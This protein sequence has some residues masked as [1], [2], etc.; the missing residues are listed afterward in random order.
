MNGNNKQFDQFK[1]YI[2][3]FDCII[4]SKDSYRFKELLK[5]IKDNES[6][7]LESY[8]KRKKEGVYY[9]NEK[10]SRFI[11]KKTIVELINKN[12]NL[13]KNLEIHIKSFKDLL[14]VNQNLK[15]KI[16]KILL[17]LSICDPTCGSGVFLTCATNL[18]FEVLQ[19]LGITKDPIEIK[20]Q[21]LRNIYGLDINP[22]AIKLCSIKL[23]AWLYKGTTFNNI[24]NL[25]SIF[26]NLKIKNTLFSTDW[27]RKLFYKK[28]FDIIVGNPPY[29]NILS[30]EEKNSLKNRNLF[31][32][33]IYCAF[34][35]RAL[36]WIDTGII[37]FLIPKSFLLRQG[38]I[39]FR[40]NFLSNASI[41]KIYDIGANLFESATNEVQ[42]IIYQKN[43]NK[44]VNLD[45]YDYPKNQICTYKN[46]EFDDLRICVNLN[47]PLSV[48]SKK[49][50]AYTYNKNC[51]FCNS[52]AIKLNRIRI[53]TSP[54]IY[55]IVNKLENEGDLNY[56]NISDFPK[57]IRGEEEKGLQ[58]V[59]KKLLN[60]SDAN[61]FYINAKDNFKHY[62]LKK[63][64]P[65]NIKGIDAKLLKGENYEYYLSPKLLIKHNNIIPQAVYTEDN[66]CFSSSIY[67]LISDDIAELKYLCAILNSALIQFY[68][69]YGINNQK[70]TTINLNQ[71]M[72]RHL[73]IIKPD[74]Q[75]KH[76]IVKYVEEIEFNLKLNN[77]N[78]NNQT[79]KVLKN[80]DDAIFNLYSVSNDERELIIS[81][82]TNQI[83]HFKTIY[84]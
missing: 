8:N 84:G 65:F 67:S 29:G 75:I 22:Y 27:P 2:N 14:E 9:T 54:E 46:Q 42:I 10:I 37:G 50:Y 59:K 3:I 35:I 57:M 82:I 41:L 78:I 20:T 16:I 68:C 24:E 12:L 77:G 13:T 70:D 72:I 52:K 17:N 53:K 55:T 81:N 19:K 40:K 83:K 47:C 45:V 31:Y 32:N 60:P 58:L 79:N 34:L 69:M 4:K 36:D 44:E 56:L 38:Y 48:K 11:I 18:L 28:N 21:I 1:K 7:F 49:F 73:P 80:I 25:N 71:Y 64:S 51:S 62:Y 63:N 5:L 61:C 33:D 15:N 39:K 6:L 76:K 74:S 43:K 26:S 66:M 23:L 30:K